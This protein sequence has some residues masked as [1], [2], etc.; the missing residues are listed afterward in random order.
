MIVSSSKTVAY[1][2]MEIALETAIPTYSGGLGV[3][4]GDTLRAAADLGTPMVA[5]TLAHRLGYFRQ[6]I[7]GD[8][9]QTESADGW[10]PEDKLEEVN[11]QAS[12]VL[13]GRK[14]QLRAW[15]FDIEGHTGSTVPVYLLDANLPE[16]APEDRRLT[17]HLYGGDTRYRLC[18]E[19][20]LGLGG[21][22]LLRALDYSRLTTY[23]MNEGHSALL[24]L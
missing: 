7:D 22:A 4:A 18:Q 3:L 21:V 19:A 9:N 20:I 12:V 6:Y 11:A 1:F 17:D 13:E 24:T 15:R 10:S 2:S 23:H 16:N 5:V 8:G 14:V